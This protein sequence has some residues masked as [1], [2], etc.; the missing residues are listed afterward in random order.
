MTELDDCFGK[1]QLRKSIPEPEKAGAS[2]KIAKSNL[3]DAKTH[4]GNKLYNWALI[5]SYASMFHSS[6]ALLFKDGVKERSHFCLCVYVRERYRGIL[7]MK[8]L[9]ELD[10]L[11]QQRH[12]IFYGDEDIVVKQVQETEADSSIKLAEG[13]LKAVGKLIEA[14]KR[15]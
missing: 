7:E 4:F 8:Y 13:F 12:R 9:N 3:E 1:G 15:K 5:A 11:R 10:V 14:G 2:L 6:R